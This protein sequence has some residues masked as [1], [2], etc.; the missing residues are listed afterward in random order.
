[1]EEEL[2]KTFKGYTSKIETKKGI[3]TAKVFE[4]TENK[5]TLI[6]EKE[7]SDESLARSFI[8]DTIKRNIYEENSWQLKLNSL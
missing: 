7:C 4:S 3:Y 8:N 5:N 2:F 6:A 1:M